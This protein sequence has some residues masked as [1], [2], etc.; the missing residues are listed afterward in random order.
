MTK[1]QFDEKYVGENIRV[2]CKTKELNDEFLELANSFGYVVGSAWDWYEDNMCYNA[3]YGSCCSLRRCLDNKCDVVEFKPSEESKVENLRHLLK[4]GRVTEL[5]NGKIGIILED[6]IM[7]SHGWNNLGS[8]HYD[9]NLK[10]LVGLTTSD[11]DI[12]KIYDCPIISGQSWCLSSVDKNGLELV[13]KRNEIKA[14]VD[15]KSI[16]KL[17]PKKYKYIAR[18]R[19]SELFIHI[20]IPQKIGNEWESPYDV[21]CLDVFGHLFEYIKWEDEKPVKISDLLNS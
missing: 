3:K 7:F 8:S 13:W 10:S 11:W 9:N 15:E 4:V 14:S 20:G 1:E 6:R 18:D 19:S 17:I 21:G 2:H 16:L 5:R 12:M